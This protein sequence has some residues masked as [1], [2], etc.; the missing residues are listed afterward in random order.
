[1]NR[2]KLE[3]LYTGDI[4]QRWIDYDAYKDKFMRLFQ[5][6]LKLILF[7]EKHL[8][9]INP[10]VPA[11]LHFDSTDAH[12]KIP[13]NLNCKRVYYYALVYRASRTTVP[14][15]QIITVQQDE[16]LISDLLS[17]RVEV[18]KNN[19]TTHSILHSI[20]KVYN[21]MDISE[22]LKVTTRN[23]E[24]MAATFS[25]IASI[26]SAKNE[27]TAKSHI[28]RLAK[29]LP[30]ESSEIENLVK[31]Q[32]SNDS[33]EL[34]SGD[35]IKIKVTNAVFST[36]PFYVH[37]A[38]IVSKRQ[39]DLSIENSN[40]EEINNK[41]YSTEFL[42]YLLEVFM[43][44]ASLWSG[45]TLELVDKTISRVSN[46]YV[47]SHN[48]IYEEKILKG[49]KD[50]TIGEAIRLLK[51]YNEC[52]VKEEVLYRLKNDKTGQISKYPS[53]KEPAAD[54]KAKDIWA[55]SKKKYDA[56]KPK[57]NRSLYLS[58][59]HIIKID[60]KIKEEKSDDFSSTSQVTDLQKNR[61]RTSNL[62][63]KNTKKV[64]RS[65]SNTVATKESSLEFLKNGLVNSLKYY[66][67]SNSSKLQFAYYSANKDVFM[68][69]KN[70][71]ISPAQFNSVAIFDKWIDGQIIDAFASTF[72]KEWCDGTY[73]PT[74]LSTMVVGRFS[75]VPMS[76]K[77]SIH[78]C[79]QQIGNKRIIP[80]CV[81]L[82]WRVLLVDVELKQCILLILDQEDIDWTVT[83]GSSQRPHQAENDIDNCGVFCM[84]YLRCL[85]E[86]TK[87]EKTLDLKKFREE[88][89]HQL[90]AKADDVTE[91]CSYCAKIIEASA[92]TIFCCSCQRRIH[93]KCKPCDERSSDTENS[94]EI[95]EGNPKKRIKV[96]RQATNFSQFACRLCRHFN[97]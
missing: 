89:A 74:D 79:E 59:Q 63:E 93:T 3:N 90:L 75:M 73:I 68:L 30:D 13:G 31:E 94:Y 9:V 22:Y 16:R 70:F 51:G 46:A 96:C 66:I 43:P 39:N 24:A 44:Y 47:E 52:L 56:V 19:F 11:V 18:I 45:I 86:K 27:T 20:L 5:L 54:H 26:L 10:G 84:Y 23:K 1:M 48:R 7:A 77:S 78:T 61:K 49:R 38:G 36:S 60:Q 37:F 95:P 17:R 15:A 92:E 81:E 85:Y 42:Q 8:E 72:M 80:Y 32:E 82:H 65:K 53:T 57:K 14:V 50:I 28:S 29:L 4:V 33:A 91:R 34:S 25:E 64:K 97:R 62:K 55:R 83:S 41:Y 58:G 69:M 71:T 40:V 6:P 21:N 88:I 76:H 67:I 35:L 87:F 12:M 2:L